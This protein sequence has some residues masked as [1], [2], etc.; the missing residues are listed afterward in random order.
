MSSRSSST[1]RHSS[2]FATSRWCRISA[3][4]CAR[5]SRSSTEGV[6]RAT[7]PDRRVRSC[8]SRISSRCRR[9]HPVTSARAGPTREIRDH[10]P[11]SP[12][13]RA[14]RA[15]RDEPPSDIST[16]RFDLSPDSSTP[17]SPVVRMCGA[18]G[19]GRG[20]RGQ[21][22]W[23]P[24]GSGVF[25]SALGGGREKSLGEIDIA[26]ELALQARDGC[27]ESCGSPSGLSCE[28]AQRREN[29]RGGCVPG[30]QAPGRRSCLEEART[31]SS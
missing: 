26:V 8:A 20:R 6:R 1:A 24:S 3:K 14:D 28:L 27:K 22:R 23:K 17:G 11:R 15:R 4:R 31:L 25:R 2:W 29:L 5:W 13:R 21:G 7:G 16:R 18:R 12:D 10:E 30:R 9:I 19:S